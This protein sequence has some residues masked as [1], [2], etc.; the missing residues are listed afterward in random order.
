VAVSPEVELVLA[1]FEAYA[2]DH[3]ITLEN[4]VKAGVRTP[5]IRDAEL[6]SI[7]LNL[8]S[9]A[10]KATKGA[11]TRRIQVDARRNDHEFKLLVS[12]TGHGISI[13]QR[14]EAFEPFVTTSA[15]D[16]ILGIGTGLGLTIVRDIAEEHDGAVRF[17]DPPEPWSTRIV[18]T[19][20]AGVDE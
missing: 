15:P 3:G 1:T 8:V 19:L 12:D 14:A 17:V 11:P 4:I 13:D 5:P 7:L 6:H 16:P 10:L 9:N 18:V 2:S 20:P